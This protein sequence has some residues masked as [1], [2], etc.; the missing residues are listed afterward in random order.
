LNPPEKIPGYATDGCYSESP[1]NVEI[2]I[3]ENHSTEQNNGMENFFLK[4]LI[5]IPE[6]NVNTSPDSALGH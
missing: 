3:T 2:C 4:E 1:S 6:N 5:K